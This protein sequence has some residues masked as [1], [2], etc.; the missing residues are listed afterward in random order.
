MCLSLRGRIVFLSSGRKWIPPSGA[1][2]NQ[3]PSLSGAR[4]EEE[5]ASGSGGGISIYFKARGILW[6]LLLCI[7]EGRSEQKCERKNAHM[8]RH[9]Q[10]PLILGVVYKLSDCGYSN[11]RGRTWKRY[12]LCLSATG[13]VFLSVASNHLYSRLLRYD[14]APELAS[15]GL[16]SYPCGFD[17]RID[18]FTCSDLCQAR[19]WLRVGAYAGRKS[20][21]PRSLSRCGSVVRW[22]SGSSLADRDGRRA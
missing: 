14:K 7:C 12:L 6:R 18:K 3:N 22:W 1:G 9:C 4:V 15:R 2:T 19:R 10:P 21:P 8:Q 11:G 5:R 16:C 13:A 17:G 20:S